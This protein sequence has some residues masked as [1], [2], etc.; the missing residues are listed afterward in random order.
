MEGDFLRKKARALELLAAA[1][2]DL[3][4]SRRL[5]EMADEFQTLADQQDR[6]NMPPAFLCKG[7]R[8]RGSGGVGHQ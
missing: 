8:S 1:C 2:F 7:G 5:R 3:D 4:I 6:P